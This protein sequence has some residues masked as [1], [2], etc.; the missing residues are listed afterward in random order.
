MRK[1]AIIMNPESGKVKSIGGKRQF[2]DILRKYDYEAEIKYT[3]KIKDAT[4]IVKNLSDDIDLVIS[5]GGDGTLNEVVTGNL[6]RKRPLVLA[7]LPMGTTNDVANMY[8]LNSNYLKNLELLLTGKIKNVDICYVNDTPFVYVACLGDYIDM[9]YNTPRELKKK[10]GKAAYIM[11]G[12]KQLRNSIHTYNIKYKIDNQEYQ[13]KASF[14]FITN[15]SR[16]A[17]VND[18]YYDIK[19]D[20]KKFEFA[21]AEVK[22]KK[23][24][25][26]LF[27]KIFNMDIKDVPDIKYYQTDNLELEFLDQ[28]KTSWCIDGEEFKTDAIK[29]NFKVDKTIKML[30]PKTNIK[31]LF[32]ED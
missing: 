5:A 27:V 12:L 24:M 22:N 26:K 28:P 31:K 3:K 13:S 4:E 2:Y 6:A 7:N 30:L 1:C 16:I 14:I 29:F 23:E 20:D 19:L 8:G 18:I 9:T 11:Y 25:L 32:N 21:F 17:G 10:Y 15:S